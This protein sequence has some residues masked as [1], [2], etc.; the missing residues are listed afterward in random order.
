MGQII[1]FTTARHAAG[2][3]A[4]ATR[5]MRYRCGDR[6]F[7]VAIGEDGIVVS[8]RRY[9][10]IGVEDFYLVRTLSGRSIMIGESGLQP[11]F[12]DGDDHG[13]RAA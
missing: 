5:A 8:A 4:P 10:L 12:D 13:G 2:H 11:V 9:A 7:L 1:D 3:P 6:V